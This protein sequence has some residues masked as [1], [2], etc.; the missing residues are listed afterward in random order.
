M[1]EFV[2]QSTNDM[3]IFVVSDLFVFGDRLFDPGI[4][5]TMSGIN[6]D[7]LS[8]VGF[9]GIGISIDDQIKSSNLIGPHACL[10]DQDIIDFL[11]LLENGMTMPT[12]NKIYSS[13]GIE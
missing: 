7:E 4:T 5:R 12:D 9:D 3:F 11:G 10:C 6:R 1:G 13:I 2:R 8:F